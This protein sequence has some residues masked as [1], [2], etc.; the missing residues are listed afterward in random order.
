MLWHLVAVYI[1]RLWLVTENLLRL[2]LHF[3]VSFIEFSSPLCKL[4]LKLSP[5]L[6]FQ[7]YFTEHDKI[8]LTGYSGMPVWGMNSLLKLKERHVSLNSVRHLEDCVLSYAMSRPC[9]RPSHCLR[10]PTKCL[11]TLLH[12]A[13][14]ETTLQPPCSIV[15]YRHIYENVKHSHV[16]HS[17]VH[18][19]AAIMY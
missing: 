10:H 7:N 11:Q 19:S 8:N 9:D 15:L 2:L 12:Y 17:T 5:I 13:E 14:N 18:E 6:K 3:Y 16:N 4:R 1:I